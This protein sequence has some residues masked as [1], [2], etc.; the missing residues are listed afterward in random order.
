[1]NIILAT[2][3]NYPHL[4]G[5]SVHIATLKAGLEAN[6][7]YVKILS[8]SDV[9]K[10]KRDLVVR[11]PAFLLNQ[12]DR[13]AGYVYTLKERKKALQD[14]LLAETENKKYDIIN[15]QDVY[16]TFAA[17]ATDVPVVST[18]HG[19]LTFE[20]IS[21][22]TVIEDSIH[23]NLLLA[24]EVKAYQATRQVITVDTRI[25]KYIE[26]EAQVTGK[27]VKN[28]IDVEAFKPLTENRSKVRQQLGLDED[29]FYF[30]VPRRLTKKN[31]VLSPI[32][33]LPTV[34]KQHPTAKVIFAGTGEMEEE[35][36][37]T[38]QDLNLSEQIKMI[39]AID[40]QDILAYYSAS[41]AVIIPSILSSGVEEATSISALEGMGSGIPVIASA[42]GGLKEIIID[43]VDGLLVEEKN[44]EAL[45]QA[46]IELI[47]NPLLC[48]SLAKNARQKIV[49]D[50]SHIAA[51]KNYEAIYREALNQK[52]KLNL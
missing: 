51:A 33:A 40:H 23:A 11:G 39:G 14:L 2:S 32:E 6:G 27:T 10:W 35:M 12:T 36:K 19:Y 21:K 28:F 7:H 49:N 41:N 48:D 30:F 15:A 46:M 20:G 38:I 18:V 47:E 29:A 17:L 16:T 50:Y 1:M 34:L 26:K 42:V 37:Q 25:R 8:F 13:G 22:G 45:S 3:Y 5:L 31:G 44:I 24:D 43:R 9:P 52:N 4:G